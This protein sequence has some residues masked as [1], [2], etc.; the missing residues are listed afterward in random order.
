MMVNWSSRRP[1][2]VNARQSEL[3]DWTCSANKLHPTENP[4]LVL[5]GLVKTFS[6]G[7]RGAWFFRGVGIVTTGREAARP[8]PNRSASKHGSLN[9]KPH[10]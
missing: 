5:L 1:C 10:H 4:P 8:F 9:Q 2:F 7:G 3:F 6:A